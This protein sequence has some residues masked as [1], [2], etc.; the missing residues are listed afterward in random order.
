LLL[1]RADASQSNG[2][3]RFFTLFGGICLLK[4]EQLMRLRE[5]FAPAVK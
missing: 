2:I 4:W 1:Y 3:Q 5:K